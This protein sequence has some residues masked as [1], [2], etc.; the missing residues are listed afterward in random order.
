MIYIYD[1]EEAVRYNTRNIF[2][3]PRSMNNREY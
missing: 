1:I 3:K 2:I